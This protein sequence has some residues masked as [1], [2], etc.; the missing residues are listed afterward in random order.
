MHG[1]YQ[2]YVGG[3][4]EKWIVSANSDHW[5]EASLCVKVLHSADRGHPCAA[6]GMGACMVVYSTTWTSMCAAGIYSSRTA[7]PGHPCAAIRM[8]GI[9]TAVPERPYAVGRAG[10]SRTEAPPGRRPARSRRT[11]HQGARGTWR[12]G[13][14]YVRE[15]VNIGN[16]LTEGWRQGAIIT[17]LWMIHQLANSLPLAWGAVE[18][19][20]WLP[21]AWGDVAVPRWLPV[22]SRGTLSCVARSPGEICQSV[23][24]PSAVRLHTGIT[25]Q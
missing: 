14:E 25:R 18:V 22:R 10:G 24:N 11:Q 6:A 3:T 4:G 17:L 15:Y 12:G 20:R 8:D 21:L 2:R 23:R 1:K 5:G 19:P 16:M 9:R 13:R 7:I